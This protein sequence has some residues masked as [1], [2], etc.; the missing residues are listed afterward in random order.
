VFISYPNL[1]VLVNQDH[2]TATAIG[3]K[4]YNALME[5]LVSLETRNIEIPPKNN[6]EEEDCVDFV[7]ATTAALG[8]PSPS[9]SKAR[10]FDDSPHSVSDQAPRK[11]DLEEEEELLR[12]L[13]LSEIDSKASISDPFVGHANDNG[14]EVSF[15]MDENTYNKQAVTVDSGVDLGKSTGKESNDF[16]ESETAIPD[17]CTVSSKHYN[18]H[19]SSTSTVGEAANSSLKNDAVSDFHQSPSIEPKESIERNEVVEKQNLDASVQIESAVTLSPE[20]Y[21][22]SISESCADGTR[23]DEKV[24]NQSSLTTIDHEV[25]DESQGPDATGVSCLSASHSN[26]DSSSIR[27]HQ[28]GASGAFPSAVDGS[29]PMYEGEECVLDPRTENI[30]D[31][32]PVYEG[33]AVLQEQADK[34]TLAKEEMTPEQ[35]RWCYILYK[36]I[37]FDWNYFLRKTFIIFIIE[38]IFDF[39]WS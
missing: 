16:H 15:G 30:E 37:L 35:G 19:I 1:H 5:K 22:V 21:S 10:S 9:L 26:S 29:E 32:E 23:R 7:A 11:G 28:T 8:V 6:P 20:K 25:S 39:Y 34:S 27:F 38:D 36:L 13:K 4:S 18:E 31:R 12:A 33:E 17:D 2:D 14:G 24:Y 3:S